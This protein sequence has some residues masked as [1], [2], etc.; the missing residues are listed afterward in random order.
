MWSHTQLKLSWEL[1]VEVKLRLSWEL[2]V[3]EV[4]V[5]FLDVLAEYENK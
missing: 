5:R 4:K 3:E 1:R 2:R